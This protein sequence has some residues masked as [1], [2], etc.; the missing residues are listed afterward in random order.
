MKKR[1]DIKLYVSSADAT[2]L[3]EGRNN[4][5]GGDEHHCTRTQDMARKHALVDADG[6]AHKHL[7]RALSDFSIDS[8]EIRLLERLETKKVKTGGGA[9]EGS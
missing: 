7:L 1:C 2:S 8:Q 6:D 5:G 4:V 9:G 3:L